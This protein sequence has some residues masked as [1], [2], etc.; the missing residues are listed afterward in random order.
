MKIIKKKLY[1]SFIIFIL[2]KI[3]ILLQVN[4]Q[5]SAPLEID[6]AYFYALNGKLFH[7]NI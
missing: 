1:I 3:F 4:N 6:D 5:R 2:L 7:S